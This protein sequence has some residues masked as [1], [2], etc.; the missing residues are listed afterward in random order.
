[1]RKNWVIFLGASLV[2]AGSL[3]FIFGC[4]SS[5]PNY[6]L[7]LAVSFSS[8]LESKPLDGRLLLMISNDGSQEP[9]FQI[10]DGPQTQLIFGL[11][12]DQLAPGEEAIFDA[13]VFGYPR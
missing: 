9:R 5:T 2:L 10:N 11:D 3:Y 12:V 13:D 7:R 1:V 8:E 4:G 6:P